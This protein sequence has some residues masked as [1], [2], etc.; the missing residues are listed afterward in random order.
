M[1]NKIKLDIGEEA[2]SKL[3]ELN[4]ILEKLLEIK[5]NEKKLQIKLKD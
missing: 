3:K 1:K 5:K 4:R 2:I